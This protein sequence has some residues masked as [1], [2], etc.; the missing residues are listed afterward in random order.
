[1][2][3]S[4]SLLLY[5]E[6]YSSVAFQ[7]LV[8][9]VIVCLLARSRSQAVFTTNTLRKLHED[10]SIAMLRLQRIEDRSLHLHE[11]VRARN[12]QQRQGGQRQE[13]DEM[14]ISLVDNDDEGDDIFE[15]HYDQLQGMA[16]ELEHHASVT[17]IQNAIQKASIEEIVAT[18]GEGPVKVELELDFHDRSDDGG[19]LDALH[20]SH[21][22]PGRKV[23]VNTNRSTK[24]AIV[25]WPDT[26]HAAWTWL[27]QIQKKLWDGTDKI[28]LDGAS[29]ALQFRPKAESEA[30]PSTSQSFLKQAW[31]RWHS[32][33]QGGSTDSYSSVDNEDDTGN[34][35]FIE[36]H[37]M[38]GDDRYSDGMNPDVIHGA[39]TVGLREAN[40][41]IE[42][43]NIE[44]DEIASPRRN[45]RIGGRKNSSSPS[46]S[47]SS[48]HNKNE[49]EMFI[50]LSD[51]QHLYQRRATCVGK[52]I[53]GFDTLQRLFEKT[54]EQLPNK[55]R[56]FQKGAVDDDGSLHI[57][58]VTLKSVTASHMT[59][60]ELDQLFI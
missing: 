60:H 19:I 45:T 14:N 39:W 31:D 48:D 42:A 56:P 10:E 44:N 40:S 18:Y 57:K 11:W 16:S 59:N 55:R 2:R 54:A 47:S 33:D 21:Q 38:D 29:T 32:T 53:D 1:M 24:I 25:L 51:N 36:Q 23:I 6:Y 37:P 28:S 58:H 13:S 9:L 8:L 17:N 50:N 22:D 4:S 35:E 12:Q 15:K 41:A 5:F 46:S 20:L 7:L 26:P 3:K 34:L 43:D 27:K 30:P 52:V 49:L